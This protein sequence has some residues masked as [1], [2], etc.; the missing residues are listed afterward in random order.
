MEFSFGIVWDRDDDDERVSFF[1]D[2]DFDDDIVPVCVLFWLVGIGGLLSRIGENNIGVSSWFSLEIGQKFH[3][4]I[5]GGAFGFKVGG[6]GMVE[7]CWF[8]ACLGG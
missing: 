2:G 5:N 1:D 4:G 8:S 6:A 7:K 3:D